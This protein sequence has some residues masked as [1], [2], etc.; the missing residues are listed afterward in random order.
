MSPTTWVLVVG[1][2][3]TR[4]F[5]RGEHG[6]LR[7]LDRFEAEARPLPDR[8]RAVL[9]ST[10]SSFDRLEIVASPGLLHAVEVALPSGVRDRISRVLDRD[11]GAV[12]DDDVG[13]L[14]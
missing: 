9:T 6:H 7:L 14:L 12:E 4:L 1:E 8:L 3:A 11:L 13:G 10:D 5:R 2:Q